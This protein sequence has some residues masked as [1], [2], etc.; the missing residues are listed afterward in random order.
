MRE[1]RTPVTGSERATKRPALFRRPLSCFPLPPAPTTRCLR[2]SRRAPR[3]FSCRHPNQD[4]GQTE[5]TSEHP[6]DRKDQAT[7]SSRFRSKSDPSPGPSEGTVDA[8]DGDIRWRRG[9]GRRWRSR[10]DEI[11]IPQTP[12]KGHGGKNLD[13]VFCSSRP[14]FTANDKAAFDAGVIVDQIHP[15]FTAVPAAQQCAL[16]GL[17]RPSEKESLRPRPGQGE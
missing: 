8:S 1:G 2:Q 4:Q 15:A 3:A 10:T 14:R 5:S 12:N 7:T 16:A 11:P 9:G 17:A 13:P 6:S